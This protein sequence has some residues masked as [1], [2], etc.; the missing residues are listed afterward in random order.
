MRRLFK[1]SK[2]RA[3]SIDMTRW[4]KQVKLRL[5]YLFRR[6]KMDRDLDD[7]M[8]FHFDIEMERALALGLDRAEAHRAVSRA[9]GAVAQ[10]IEECR[11]VNRI[12]F[13]ENL[14]RDV[15]YGVRSLRKTPVVA[16]VAILTLALGIGANT[17]LFSVVDVA[18]LRKPPYSDPGRVVAVFTRNTAPSAD[19]NVMRGTAG[20][21][22][23]G[24]SIADLEDFRKQSRTVAEFAIMSGFSANL[25]GHQDPERVVG[26]AVSPNF[27]ALLGVHPVAG[28]NFYASD[29]SLAGD[30]TVLLSYGFWQ[31]RWR[32]DLSAIG[33]TILLDQAPYKVVGIIPEGFRTPHGDAPELYRAVIPRPAPANRGRRFW[34]TIARMKTEDVGRVRAELTTIAAQLEKQ[35]PASNRGYTISVTPLS[36]LVPQRVRSGLLALM[37]SV[38]LLLLIACSNIAN[39]LLARAARRSREIATRQAL[40]ASGRQLIQQFLTEN[41][42]IAILGGALGLLVA[43]WGIRILVSAAPAEVPG[44]DRVGIDWRVLAFNSVVALSSG[45]FFSL[46]P[47][48]RSLRTER[49]ES[50]LLSSRAQGGDS[51]TKFMSNALVVVQIGLAVVLLAEAGVMLRSFQRLQAVEPGFRSDDVIAFQVSMSRA[52]FRGPEQSAALFADLTHRLASV[53]GVDS[54]GAI[55]QLPIKGQDVDVTQIAVQG[56]SLPADQEPTT[57]LHVVSPGYFSTLKIPLIRGRFFTDADGRNAPG[58]AVINEA[59]ARKIWGNEDPIGKRI[60]Q[61]L[62][63]VPGDKPERVV[64]GIAGNVKHFG[65]EYQDEA[66]M[67]VPHGQSPWPAMYFVVRTRVGI[68]SMAA[69]LKQAVWAVDRSLPVDKLSTMDA[70]LSRSLSPP[71]VRAFLVASFGASA[72]LLAAIGIYGVV[73][74]RVTQRRREIAIRLAVGAKRMSIV[75]LILSDSL[76]LAL[77]GT[78]I[79]LIVSRI[80]SSAIASLLFGV[81]PTDPLT[82]GAVA[83][84]CVTVALFASFIP[85]KRAAKLDPVIALRLD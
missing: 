23:S 2:K 18:L 50:L 21:A 3:R 1:R 77:I 56:R 24:L 58:V 62:L 28:R 45:L 72:I 46:L 76:K 38:A 64:V 33:Q 83:V 19:A 81:N 22:E 15:R 37:I 84:L 20:A 78:V 41:M 16:I 39:L 7:E 32:G 25:T 85:A 71:K 8:R 14:V 42:L 51:R 31:R 75:Q 69:A 12:L 9:M 30:R 49:S 10:N 6:N 70:V 53:P 44:L 52:Q 67:Y 74:Y 47:I 68:S 66:Q 55:L 79:G 63:L 73:S 13:I 34:S 27:F 4:V 80:A 36:D 61:R 54:A 60:T 82:M 40:G 65:L 17:A 26:A 29:D 59:M 48:V 5:R 11:D 57:R 35:Y 43:H